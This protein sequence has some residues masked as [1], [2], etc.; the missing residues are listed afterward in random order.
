VTPPAP[1][2]PSAP[3]AVSPNPQVTVP[4]EILQLEKHSR[5]HLRLERPNL[6][7]DVYLTADDENAVVLNAAFCGGDAGSTQYSGH[8]Q[9]VSVASQAVVSRLDLDP[10]VNFVEKKPHDSARLYREPKT[11]QN[12]IAL[13]QYGSCNSETVQFFSV[14]PSAQL[15]AIPFLDKDGHAGKQMVT[16]PDGAIPHFANGSSVFCSYSS[17]TRY[18]YCGAYAFDGANFQETAKWMTKD[19]HAPAQGLNPTSEATRTLFDFLSELSLNNYRAA[20]YHF[21]GKAGSTAEKPVALEDYC[22]KQGG[23]CL[24]PVEIESQPGAD[25]AGAMLFQVS[26][27]TAEFK[28]FHIGAR[29]TFDFHVQKIGGEFKVLDLPPRLP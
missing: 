7:V 27:Q 19:L 25:A 29:S 18:N 12:L 5:S 10:D 17:E 4:E 13:F 26:F 23:Q 9:L 22:T 6:S 8:Y 2:S 11:G 20:G 3:G 14:D 24:A 15:Y 21:A 16:G 28:P 1:D